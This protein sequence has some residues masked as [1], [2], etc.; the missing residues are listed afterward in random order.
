[1]NSVKNHTRNQYKGKY[2][3]IEQSST[4]QH[5]YPIFIHL[6]LSLPSTP[7]HNSHNNNL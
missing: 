5:N 6:T 4:E 7:N 1:M 3:Q 2:S